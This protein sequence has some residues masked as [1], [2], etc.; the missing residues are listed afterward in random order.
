MKITEQHRVQAIS[1][2]I[3]LQEYGV[4]IFDALQ[5]KS[6]LKKAIKRKSILI[7]G[8]VAETSTWIQEGQLIELKA[9]QIDTE[10]KV[11]NL[12]LNVVYEDEDL[13][14][15]EKPVG[16]PT[17]GNYFK[18]IEN[19]LPFNLKTSTKKDFLPYPQPVHRLDNP[20]SGL[21]LV[22]K[23]N[24]AKTL[25]SVS[26]ENN[27]IHKTYIAIAHGSF[28]ETAG[29]FDSKIDNKDSKTRFQVLEKNNI[30]VANYSFLKLFPSTGRTHQIRIHLSNSGHPILGDSIYGLTDDKQKK[31]FLHAVGIQFLHPKKEVEMSFETD[32][33]K[34]FLKFIEDRN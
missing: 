15:I 13:A 10:R 16:F 3:R 6:A 23:T 27:S 20:T 7:D 26:F 4:G 8:E 28:E 29:V 22:A 17:N 14:V 9:G 21:L 18:T 19:A 33:P 24:S 30:G 12:K 34:R 31:L 5:T 25:L 2:K 1:E 32:I 11:F